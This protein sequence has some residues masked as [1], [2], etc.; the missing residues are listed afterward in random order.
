MNPL[1]LVIPIIFG[2]FIFALLV[3]DAILAFEV[4][5][6]NNKLA[7]LARR[8]ADLNH[9]LMRALKGPFSATLNDYARIC[10]NQAVHA[11]WYMDL[12]TG[13]PKEKNVGESLMLMVSELAEAMEGHRKDLMDD[14]LPHRKMCEVELADTLIRIFDFAG[15]QGFDLSGAVTE[16]LAYNRERADHKP[17]NRLAVGGKAY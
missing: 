8:N 6:R 11:G 15:S 16:K 17:A 2:T 3:S 1:D 7:A 5:S 13:H 9:A 12:K 4:R 10:Y 14:K